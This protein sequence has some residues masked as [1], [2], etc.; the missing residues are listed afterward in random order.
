MRPIRCHISYENRKNT[1]N[2]QKNC[3]S[4]VFITE[5]HNMLKKGQFNVLLKGK[6]ENWMVLGTEGFATTTLLVKNK[7]N[8]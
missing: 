2:K 3:F 7:L 5:K 8:K 6:T 1:K 4:F